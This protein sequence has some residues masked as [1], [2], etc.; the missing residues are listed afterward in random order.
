[1]KSRRILAIAAVAASCASVY[2]QPTCPPTICPPA[3]PSVTPVASPTPVTS[4]VS[5]K[6]VQSRYGS[7]GSRWALPFE[8]D[9]NPP[10]NPFQ[11][12]PP[13]FAS[14]DGYAYP[15]T[16]APLSAQGL[17]RTGLWDTAQNSQREDFAKRAHIMAG[18]YAGGLLNIESG[19]E[20]TRWREDEDP[21]DFA[22]QNP[23]QAKYAMGAIN[24]AGALRGFQSEQ[25]EFLLR[26]PGRGPDGVASTNWI[27]IPPEAVVPSGEIGASETYSIFFEFPEGSIRRGEHLQQGD[28]VQVL[29]VHPNTGQTAGYSLRVR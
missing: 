1:M 27:E 18:F 17:Y 19:F 22:P 9:W 4:N 7:F 21:D 23:S 28:I 26:L 12:A 24:H 16:W 14:A 25:P 8:G 3:T 29:A 6:S 2:A 10:A 15:N 20:M 5:Y 13:P 11:F